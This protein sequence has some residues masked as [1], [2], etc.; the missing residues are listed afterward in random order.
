MVLRDNDVS[1]HEPTQYGTKSNMRH[2]FGAQEHGQCDQ[3]TDVSFD[4][5]KEGDLDAALR[6]SLNHG[7]EQ[8]RQPREERNEQSPPLKEFQAIPGEMHAPQ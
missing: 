6:V 3:E 7:Q 4:V 5:A 8:K 2:E 1:F